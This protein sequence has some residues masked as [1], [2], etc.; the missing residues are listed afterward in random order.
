MSSLEEQINKLEKILSN[1][2]A[3]INYLE[4]EISNRDEELEEIEILRKNNMSLQKRLKKA[5][6][7]NITSRKKSTMDEIQT[8]GETIQNAFV[9]INSIFQ[10]TPAIPRSI[11]DR[12]ITDIRN[13][14]T[15]LQ[16]ISNF[17]KNRANTAE[18]KINQ[19]TKLF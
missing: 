18:A 12:E 2:E 15:R 3:Y 17:E 11:I 4:K 7:Q 1:N 8:L 16:G 5:L 13:A 9:N 10:R 14:V 6:I 19:D